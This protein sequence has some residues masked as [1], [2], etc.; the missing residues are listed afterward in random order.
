MSENMA[1]LLGIRLKKI[2]I[3]VKIDVIYSYLRGS[4]YF[5]W[6][7]VTVAKDLASLT[8]THDSL[9]RQGVKLIKLTPESFMQHAKTEQPLTHI[10]KMRMKKCMRYLDKGYHGVALL[11]GQEVYGDI[12]YTGSLN[13]KNVGMHPDQKWLLM[14][15]EDSDAYGFD[16]YIHPDKRG[17]NLA[18]L[19]LNG[20]LHEMQREGYT[21][22]LGYYW[23]KNI[24]ALWVHRTLK[25]NELGTVRVS[26]F[27]WLRFSRKR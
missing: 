12:W 15:C 14:Q 21:R 1:K 17:K 23:A 13:K 11:M 19:L 3:A 8:P 10:D 7:A 18:T 6:E 5:D 4:I 2:L 26:R 24:P 20:A 9:E 16:M 27:L 22:A 25:F